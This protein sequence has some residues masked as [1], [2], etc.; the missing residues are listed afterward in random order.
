M[1]GQ[2]V[3][4]NPDYMPWPTR[5]PPT[6]SSPPPV[7]SPGCC[8]DFSVSPG[9]PLGSVASQLPS[10]RTAGLIKKEKDPHKIRPITMAIKAKLDSSVDDELG[11]HFSLSLSEI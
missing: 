1:K 11:V 9:D 5:P 2:K 8:L 4:E 3:P 6:I 7:P 10:P